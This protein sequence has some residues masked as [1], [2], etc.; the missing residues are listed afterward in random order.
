MQKKLRLITTYTCTVL[1][2][3][4]FS[5]GCSYVK[6]PGVYRVPVQ[7]G[8]IIDKEKVDQLE[9]GMTKRQ[10]QF[11]MGAPLINDLFTQDRWDY[12]YQFRRGD[13]TLRSRRLTVFFEND[14]LVRFEGDYESDSDAA[15]D[16]DY[17]EDG[18]RAGAD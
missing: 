14:Q 3:T 9:P 17:V 12:V 4:L 2:I 18:K 6:F 15:L 10:V 7:Q 5:S 1:F 8:N 11:V 16:E 13:E